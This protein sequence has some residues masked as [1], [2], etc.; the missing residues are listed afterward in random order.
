MYDD[1]DLDQLIDQGIISQY[2]CVQCRSRDIKP[3]TYISHSFSLRYIFTVLVPLNERMKDRLIV[4]IGSRLGVVLYAVNAYGRGQVK[5]IGIEMNE[6]FCAL[7]RRAIQ[8]NGMEAN[9]SVGTA[10]YNSSAPLHCL[11]QLSAGFC[12]VDFPTSAF[13]L[14]QMVLGLPV[15][16]KFSISLL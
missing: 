5:A 3:L 12:I 10:Q 8:A 9:I 7:Q 11:S 16:F 1:D 2:Y 4:D 13:G 15:F 6:D 14:S